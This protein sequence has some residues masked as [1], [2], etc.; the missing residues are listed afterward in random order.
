MVNLGD[1]GWLIGAVL[2]A[3]FYVPLMRGREVAVERMVH[4]R[5]T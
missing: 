4:S 5:S 2:G 1:W 3:F